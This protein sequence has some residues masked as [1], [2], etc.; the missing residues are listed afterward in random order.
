MAYSYSQPKSLQGTRGYTLVELVVVMVLLGIVAIFSFSYI[1]FWGA[2]LPRYHR[3][4]QLVS[5]T[6]FAVTRLFPK[7]FAMPCRVACG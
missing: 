5:Q 7:K 4:E 3:R 2:Y 1:A 6:R